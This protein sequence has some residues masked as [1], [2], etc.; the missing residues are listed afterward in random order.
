MKKKQDVGLGCGAFEF[1]GDEKKQIK[2]IL[3]D[4]AGVETLNEWVLSVYPSLHEYPTPHTYATQE[5]SNTAGYASLTLP[6]IM[7]I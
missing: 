6:K 7:I 4:M 5:H 3:K 1:K 2:W